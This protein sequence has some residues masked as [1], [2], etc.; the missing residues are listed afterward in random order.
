MQIISLSTNRLKSW[1]TVLEIAGAVALAG[2]GAFFVATSWRK[3]PDP[4]IDFGQQLYNA[5]QLANGAVLYR[6]IGCLYGPLSEYFNAAVFWIFGEGL[7]VL[8]VANLVIF[9]AI[10][11]NIYLLIRKGWGALAAWL[12]T[13]IFISVFGF[14]QFVDEG[15][16]NYATPYANEAIHGLLICLLLCH[17]LLSW[18]DKPTAVRSVLCG[19]LFGATIVLKP[20]FILAGVVL[21]SLAGLMRWRYRGL[22]RAQV[23]CWWAIAAVLPAMLF[24]AYFTCFV[25]PIR[26]ASAALQGLLSAFDRSLNSSPLEVRLLGL[27]HPWSNFVEDIIAAALACAII[28]ALL[29]AIVL[30]E[31]KLPT[32]LQLSAAVVVVAIFAGL[33]CYV[34]NWAEIGR[35]L[36]VLSVVYLVLAIWAFLRSVQQANPDIAV[37]ILRLLVAGLAVTLLVRMFLSPRI[38]HYGFYQAAL[39]ALLIPAVI[40]AELPE[41]LRAGR[42]GK[43]M[44]TAAMLAIILPGIANLA[45]RSQNALRLKTVAITEGRDRFYSFPPEMDSIGSVVNTVTAALREKAS[46]ETLTVLPEGE[47]INYF[48]RLRNPVPHA[49]FYTGSMETQSEAELVDDLQ[50][51]SPYW[52][53]VIRRDLIAFG[54]ERYGE[55]SGSGKEVLNWVDQNYKQVSA[56]GG[57]PLD[58]RERGAI[59]LRNYSR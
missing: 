29:G 43:M 4:L 23:M 45:T 53:V 31:R 5:W 19:L 7:I 35:C 25:P 59:I 51:H 2:A 9:A 17:A 39:A 16:Y 8:A 48:A 28:V 22:P 34:L 33:G 13:L 52:I 10:S 26:A 21:T 42:W 36:F 11:V 20:E 47:S 14:S 40:I 54:I 3:W 6:D 30:I 56:I 1:R 18:I 58:Y 15:N 32:W 44:A 46:G 24:A 12:S 41:W 37:R 57:D 27:D 55:K 38:Y 49:C 50:S